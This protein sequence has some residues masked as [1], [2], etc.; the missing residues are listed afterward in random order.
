VNSFWLIIAVALIG[1]TVITWPLSRIKKLIFWPL[2]SVLALVLYALWGGFLPVQN[3]L[4]KEQAKDIIASMGGIDNI[5]EKL[6]A[7][8]KANPDDAKA[9]YLLGRVYAGQP[10]WEKAKHAFKH[11]RELDKHNHKYTLH[12]A[13]SVWHTN[14]EQ[15]DE[16]TRAL[17]KGLLQ[18]ETTKQ[19][20]L[21]MLAMD[22]YNQK[23]YQQAIDY[24]E[25]LLMLIPSQSE[26]AA[27][28]RQA[29]T[30]AEQN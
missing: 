4:K 26:E 5:V 24:W 17:L 10:V 6:E 9:W 13:E 18:D 2:L 28:L 7:T 21:A 19:D 15:F 16:E 14:Q 22:A 29:I 12:Y 1:I 20:A 23:Q 8:V 3:A 30:K 27:K 25:Q 11:A